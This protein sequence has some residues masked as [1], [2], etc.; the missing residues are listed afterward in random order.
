MHSTIGLVRALL[1]PV[2]GSL[3]E[4]TDGAGTTTCRIYVTG[5]TM[6]FDGLDEIGRRCPGIDTAVLH[7]GGTTLPGG[8]VVTMT[9]PDAVECLRRVRP[10]TAVPIHH[11][12]YGV[13]KSS[14]EEV[15]RSV[16]GAGLD[17]TL[18]CV[19]RGGTVPLAP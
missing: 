3:L 7:V 4:L 6:V 12:D 10:R 9:G 19:E 11:G 5:D 17:V 15:V 18:R 14:L 16:D 1:P 8:I 2:M 13:F